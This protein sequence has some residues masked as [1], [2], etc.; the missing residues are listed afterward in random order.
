M[1]GRKISVGSVATHQTL[2]LQAT[3]PGAGG[4]SLAER[5][6]LEA[7]CAAAVGAAAVAV[8]DGRLL[9]A[10]ATAAAALS[11]E[12]LEAQ[13]CTSQGLGMLL[14]GPCMPPQWQCL[15]RCVSYGY[16]ENFQLMFTGC[17]GGCL[18]HIG[19][20]L[21]RQTEQDSQCKAFV[22]VKSFEAEGSE[23]HFREAALVSADL[24]G[25]LDGST[26]VNARK[27][28][29]GAVACILDVPRASPP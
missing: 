17:G 13:A 20:H 28:G 29:V 14:V 1:S 5:A 8:A 19:Q 2:C 12:A 9:L 21:Q 23:Q 15:Q 26:R 25:L 4:I 16:Q 11:C 27:G 18:H 7:G 24:R 6:V 3:E 22:Q 10:A